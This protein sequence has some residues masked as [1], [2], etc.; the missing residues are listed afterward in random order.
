MFKEFKCSKGSNVLKVQ[1]LRRSEGSIFQRFAFQC[2]AFQSFSASRFR[3]HNQQSQFLNP[4]SAIRNPQS[5]IR[6]PQSHIPHPT[7]HIRHP[8]FYSTSSITTS[9]WLLSTVSPSATGISL[10][11]PALVALN[12]LSIFIAETMITV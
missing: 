11:T 8:Q 10:T 4:Q 6:N 7:S 12:S 2:F 3:V 9:T 5:A 1:C